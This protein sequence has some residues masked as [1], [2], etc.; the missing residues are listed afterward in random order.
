MRLESAIAGRISRYF[1]HS[2]LTPLLAIGCLVLGLLAFCFTAKEEMP[3]L[4]LTVAELF[5]PFAGATP[6]QV[7][8]QVTNPVEQLLATLPAIDNLYSISR[9]GGALFSLI[10]NAG[11]SHQQALVELHSLLFANRS[12]APAGSNVGEPLLEV[13]TV[14][15][16]PLLA[17]T[18]WS[19]DSRFSAQELTLIAHG[20]AAE[21]KQ[22]AGTGSVAVVGEQPLTVRVSV[23]P[24]RLNGYG[25][26]W[27]QLRRVLS[28]AGVS[29]DPQGLT[30][31]NE[32]ISVRVGAFLQSAEDVAELVVA[33]HQGKPV[34]LADV[35]EV[36]L[37]A[38]EPRAAVWQQL[39]AQAV[40]AVTL[41]IAKQPGAN[42]AQ[43]TKQIH[44][45]LEA[46]RPLLLPAGVELTISRDSGA[47]AVATVN[48]LIVKLALLA[49]AAAL[50]V[51][52]TLG[53]RAALVVAAPLVASLGLVFAANWAWGF[54]FNR[55]SLAALIIALGLWLVEAIVLVAHLQRRGL[56]NDD[57]DIKAKS[58]GIIAAIGELGRPALFAALA[59]IA[60]LL[61]LAFVGGWLGPYLRPL[62]ITISTVLLIALAVIFILLPYLAVRW[63][64]VKPTAVVV[65]AVTD[66]ASASDELT[67]QPQPAFDW[68]QLAAKVEAWL[69]RS[70]E[71]LA[72]F[73]SHPKAQLHRYCLAGGLGVALLLA[74]LLPLCGGVIVKA[75]PVD[76]QPQLQLQVDL[77]AGATLEQS[78]RLLMAMANIISQKVPEVSGQQLYAGTASPNSV[79]ALLLPD[80]LRRAPHLGD[81]HL[82]LLPR[83]ERSHSSHEIA[84]RLRPLLAELLTAN[85]AVLKVME[86]PA[87][88]PVA[89]PLVAEIYGPTAEQRQQA[90]AQLQQLMLATSGI[91]DVASG[92]PEAQTEWQIR[93][94][95]P[96]AARL[97]ISEAD[98]VATISQALGGVDVAYLQPDGPRQ[99]LPIRLRVPNAA[100]V[101]LDGI[102]SLRLSA[103]NGARVPLDEL[104][105]VWRGTVEVPIVHK[106]RQSV[107]MVSANVADGNV[108]AGQAALSDALHEAGYQW[109]QLSSSTGSEQAGRTALELHWAGEWQQ[110]LNTLRDFGL[111]SVL[112]LL[113]IY[114]LLAA[115]WRSYSLPL[116]IM[117][118]LPLTLIA[119]LPA[120]ALLGVEFTAISLIGLMLLAGVIVRHGNLLLT[121]INQQ[122]A[123]GVALTTA[124]QQGM[125]GQIKPLLLASAALMLAALFVLGD[126]LVS[127]LA[128]SLLFGLVVGTALT[129]LLI[130]LLYWRYL[131]WQQAR[132]LAVKADE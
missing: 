89:A 60:A 30:Q 42:T 4:E 129:L 111:A 29:S 16:L 27:P 131:C 105:Q 28:A 6:E 103:A 53:W 123:A 113:L 44:A 118:P 73:I 23:D 115:Q 128:I 3:P 126:P 117:A 96:R 38:D 116:L 86:Q 35:A 92:L 83:G 58:A 61:P 65:E 77:P 93:V 68:Q 130:P 10:F 39:S 51:G 132:A 76:D 90:A 13:R 43:L 37:V 69:A 36:R 32:Q 79:N 46:T 88:Q 31:N 63:L 106:N 114:L 17:L 100:Q 107:V 91:V 81:I 8:Q 26:D 15:E 40:P 45:R 48:G 34:Y 80:E 11:I 124:L 62:P 7:E 55:I 82:Q 102:L 110:S 2:P 49:V 66:T 12:W 109:R 71:L 101:D 87:G 108:R 20:L 22:L 24:A 52:L 125:A 95:R 1:L 112:G 85:G 104:V 99:R 9:T 97:G 74:L 72:I 120:H 75:L 25:L 41:T 94:D 119:V 59:L 70:A 54:S 47:N 64:R 21:I 33:S 56:A 122:Q 57:G 5:I 14:D 67:D 98:I 127:G 78:Q 84:E 19:R 121:A 18:L 50:L